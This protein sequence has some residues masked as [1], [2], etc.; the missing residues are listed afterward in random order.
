[1]LRQRPLLLRISKKQNSWRQLKKK[2]GSDD[3]SELDNTLKPPAEADSNENMAF[4]P[5]TRS[6][7]I[8]INEQHC[9]LS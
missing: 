3:K 1:L 8:L 5:G 4:L 9:E 6:F 2:A 7:R